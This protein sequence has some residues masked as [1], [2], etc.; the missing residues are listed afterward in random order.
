MDRHAPP[1]KV[2]PKQ[3]FFEIIFR[4]HFTAD[5]SPISPALPGP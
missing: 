1:K 4:P 5:T 3:N 2:S